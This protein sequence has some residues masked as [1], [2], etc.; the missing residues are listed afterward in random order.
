[1]N[2]PPLP[3]LLSWLL[4]PLAGALL[5]FAA[6]H[7]AA[8]LLPGFLLRRRT[9]IAA[10]VAAAISRELA[11][12]DNPLRVAHSP[13]IRALAS[14]SAAAM[15]TWALSQPVSGVVRSFESWRAGS[16]EKTAAEVVRGFL[17]SRSFIYAVRD[18]VTGLVDQAAALTVGDM[19]RRFNLESLVS[20]KLLALLSQERNRRRIAESVATAVGGNVGL[21]L[22]DDILDEIAAALDSYI[23]I[24]VESLARWLET[25]ETRAYLS[26]RGRE[27]LPRILEKLNVMQKLFL[28]AGQFDRR[29][30][31]KMPEIVDEIVTALEKIARDGDPQQRILRLLIDAARQWRDSLL[32]T[33]ADTEPDRHDSRER[34]A[35]A[36]ATAVERFLEKLEDPEVRRTM[37]QGLAGRVMREEQTLSA[38][39]RDV[40]GVREAEAVEFLSTRALD[41]L[42][43]PETAEQIARR[44]LGLAASSLKEKGKVTVGEALGID[45]TRRRKLDSFVEARLL[46]LLEQGMPQLVRSLD[47]TQLTGRILD[48]IDL[49]EAAK[50]LAEAGKPVF[51]AARLFGAALGCAI[52]LVLPLL[53]LVHLA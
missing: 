10:V 35:H 45:E 17:G 25:P 28:T 36:A 18:V 19:M 44:A 20:D 6:C 29:L 21:F 40:F 48:A 38:L 13:L 41:W 30:T 37:A 46:V 51:R 11:R 24:A 15:S 9:R 22:G 14:R 12:S 2:L 8:A 50:I 49:R 5:G 16:L 47:V 43:R 32:V 3:Q 26:D 52:G 31:E 7:A 39:A 4:P 34:L 23:P 1:M 42:T 33:Y 53:R 27:L